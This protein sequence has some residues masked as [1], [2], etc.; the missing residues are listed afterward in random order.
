MP[1]I[2]EGIICGGL[3]DDLS[4]IGISSSLKNFSK[5]DGVI[6]KNSFPTDFPIFLYAWNSSLG[7]L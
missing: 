7:D 1:S 4:S 5:W 3:N 6:I 2:I